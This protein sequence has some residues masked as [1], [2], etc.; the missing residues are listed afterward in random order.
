M[1]KIKNNKTGWIVGGV[2]VG[3]GALYLAWDKLFKKKTP[4]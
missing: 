2:L 3:G 1:D 4:M